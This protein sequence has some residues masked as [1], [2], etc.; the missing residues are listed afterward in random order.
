[1]LDDIEISM[2]DK[3]GSGHA[4]N[5]RV[6]IAYIGVLIREELYIML[7]RILDTC[8]YPVVS[9]RKLLPH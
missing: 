1:M 3:G 8:I 5:D 9:V 7:C 4:S 6:F 2:K